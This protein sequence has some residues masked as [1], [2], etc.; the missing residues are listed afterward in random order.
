MGTVYKKSYTRTLPA[1][2][3]RFTRK[4]IEYAR[5]K[6]RTGKPQTGRITTGKDGSVRVLVE[7]ATYTAKYR[8]GSG[9]VR[10]EA[11]GCRS[12]DGAQAVLSEMM[13]RAA[14]VAAGVMSAE[15]SAAADWSGVPM[16]EHIKD[17]LSHLEGAGRTPV[18]VGRFRCH[19]NRVVESCKWNRLQDA[20]RRKL[21]AFLADTVKDGLSFRTRNAILTACVSF[22]NWLVRDG[23]MMDNP[24]KG[25]A[26]LN[27]RT[28]RRHVRRVLTDKEIAALLDAAEA[29]PLHAALHGNRGDKPANL[30]DGTLE[31]LRL[32]GRERRLFYAV[33]LETGLR[34]NEARTLRVRELHLDGQA[35]IDVAPENE[36]A[37]RGAR[38]PLREALAREIGQHLTERLK[39]QQRAAQ[40]AKRPIPVQLSVDSPAFPDAPSNVRV[41]DADLAFAGIAKRDAAGRVV[42]FHAMRHTYGTRLARGGVSLQLAQRLMR[43][44]TPALTSNLYTHL[45]MGDMHGA[46]ASLPDLPQ[47]KAHKAQDRAAEAGASLAPALAP[48]LAPDSG[49]RCHFAA[50]HGTEPSNRLSIRA[51]RVDTQ[52]APHLQG[53]SPPDN[54]RQEKSLVGREGFEPSTLGL[55]VPCSTS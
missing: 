39:V 5:W 2:A 45:D 24:F 15:E 1:D 14:K 22:G 25:I 31:A 47:T 30:T 12:K 26:K 17:F 7:T 18:H 40:A 19:L 52:K 36:K 38:L 49:K 34:L 16:A 20:N 3:E 50:H 33:L 11:T 21:E 42:D 54:A 10:E 4:G 41:L 29:R 46:M 51:Q 8:D 44:S 43:H 32:L 48:T 28:D 53:F 55:R 35:H 13:A 27:E 23:R 6:D 9:I 37:R